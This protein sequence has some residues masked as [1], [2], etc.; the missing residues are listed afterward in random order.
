M[1]VI[2]NKQLLDDMLQIFHSHSS[3]QQLTAHN[4]GLL[5]VL[6]YELL[7]G[8]NK[9]IAG[10]GSLKRSLLKHQEALERAL[11]AAQ[12][13]QQQETCQAKEDV[14]VLLPR[15]VRINTLQTD[16]SAAL[17]RLQACLRD[18]VSIYADKHVP[19]LLVLPP[20]S[21]A[22]LK[23]ELGHNNDTDFVLQDKSSCFSALC[24]VH[25]F[26]NA[27]LTGDC[28]DACAA[29]GNKTSHLAAL[30]PKQEEGRRA[31][32]ALDRDK[33][34]YVMLKSR[35]RRLVPDDKASVGVKVQAQQKDFLQTKPEDYATV[36]YILLDPSCSGSG[37][38]AKQHTVTKER[39]EQLSSFQKK[40]L[41][42]AMSFS[43]VDRIVYS[44]CSVHVEE[45][46]DVVA[47]C[48][49]GKR[50]EWEVIPPR[51]L[52]TWK[53]RGLPHD[54]LTSEESAALIR[55]DAAEDETNGFFVCCLQRKR[56]Q[57]EKQA[58]AW[59]PVARN[60]R[61]PLY[62]GEFKAVNDDSA[63]DG[64][65]ADKI[66]KKRKR[67]DREPSA[68]Q[69]KAPT[70]EAGVSSKKRAKKLE[71]QRRQHELKMERIEAKKKNK[72]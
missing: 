1:K 65:K 22:V 50:D 45:N 67:P 7:L 47:G 9:S 59:E 18:S 27:P 63:K 19:D 42:H 60:L 16:A 57:K 30:L 11:K 51:C 48:L 43:Q 66:K 17:E 5:Y 2:Q 3:R 61:I 8:P 49:E 32:V 69:Q 70:G 31:I 28:L 6:L 56:K 44:T 21:T 23:K 15:Y 4:Q 58:D 35:M 41:Q 12:E 36:R 72:T 20:D 71:W 68:S 25:G 14:P 38:V 34:R 55:V 26:S 10:G 39:V 33:T 54:S 40:A 64:P 29:P 24:L 52:T 62:D 46:E 53:R 13:K 37:M